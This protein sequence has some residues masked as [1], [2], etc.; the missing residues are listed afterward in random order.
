MEIYLIELILWLGF[1]AIIW[2]L[3][4]SLREMDSE[5]RLRETA[6]VA[7]PR[8]AAPGSA[9]QTLIEPIG[10]Y[11][12]RPI[13][14]YAIIEGKIYHFDHVCPEAQAGQ[15]A[16]DQKWITP[17]LVYVRDSPAGPTLVATQGLLTRHRSPVSRDI[18]AR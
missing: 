9:V 2:A 16:V 18:S 10:R 17:G 5:I 1:G 7:P 14:R 6:M 12:D 4:T 13:Y 3:R 8:K 15:L 11:L